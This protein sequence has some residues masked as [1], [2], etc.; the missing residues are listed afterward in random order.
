MSYTVLSKNFQGKLII[1]T[2]QGKIHFKNI[3]FFDQKKL[4]LKGLIQRP[5]SLFAV[6][7]NML[8]VCQ[9]IHVSSQSATGLTECYIQLV[10]KY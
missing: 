4:K 5:E 8:P 7:V 9:T 6:N 2:F 10:L 3:S 1:S